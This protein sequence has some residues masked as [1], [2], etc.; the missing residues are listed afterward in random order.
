[1]FALLPPPTSDIDESSDDDENNILHTNYQDRYSESSEA[2][3]LPSPIAEQ[4]EDICNSSDTDI[5]SEQCEELNIEL[6]AIKT[7]I[8][9]IPEDE[10][11]SKQTYVFTPLKT[12]SHT[13][14]K[15][16]E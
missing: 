13:K 7:P 9:Y 5:A 10:A 8:K 4:L 15:R 2:P 11:T 12:R 1:M 6:Q 3:K 16:Q 14:K